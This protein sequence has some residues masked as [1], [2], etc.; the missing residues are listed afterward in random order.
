MAE[1]ISNNLK[2][3]IEDSPEFDPRAQ[4][5]FIHPL[6][7][8]LQ[9]LLESLKKDP[10]SNLIEAGS[11]MEA[12][13]IAQMYK[14]CILTGS[15][16]Q[17][18]DIVKMF[19][20]FAGLKS[21]I[22][23]NHIK[24]ML[25]SAVKDTRIVRKFS[26][27]GCTDY[28]FEPVPIRQLLHKFSLQI[29][30]NRAARKQR[31]NKDIDLKR[32]D[33]KQFQ[34]NNLN[35]EN[36]ANLREL[37]ANEVEQDCWITRGKPRL[38]DG[39]WNV[40]MIGPPTHEGRWERHNDQIWKYVPSDPKS[41]GPEKGNWYFSGQKPSYSRLE[42]LFKSD[43]PK[44]YFQD[45]KGKI[46][47]Y[48]LN[49]AADEKL[50]MA[51]D[52]AIAQQRLAEEK[53]QIEELANSAEPE[54][55][56]NKNKKETLS[57]D[58]HVSNSSD[59]EKETPEDETG[60][61]SDSESNNLQYKSLKT[62]SQDKA[63]ARKKRNLI[64]V[65]P[66]AEVDSPEANEDNPEEKALKRKRASTIV[67]PPGKDQPKA[68]ATT[69]QSPT[70]DPLTSKTQSPK[71]AEEEPTQRPMVPPGQI[72]KN[73]SSKKT[74][75]HNEKENSG[76][77]NVPK[78]NDP[79][80]NS[81]SGPN[82]T[83]AKFSKKDRAVRADG[84]SL[85]DQEPDP[86]KQRRGLDQRNF[87][88]KK[89]SEKGPNPGNTRPKV[90]DQPTLNRKNSEENG[91]ENQPLKSKNFL[92]K[93]SIEEKN[94]SHSED[95]TNASSR[96]NKGQGP[97]TDPNASKVRQPSANHLERKANGSG[98]DVAGASRKQNETI[99]KNL[100][101]NNGNPEN[102]PNP[103]KAAAKQAPK[104]KTREASEGSPTIGETEGSAGDNFQADDEDSPLTPEETS[105]VSTDLLSKDEQTL[106]TKEDFSVEF[107]PSA[108]EPLNASE[109]LP[110]LVLLMKITDLLTQRNLPL[111]QLTEKIFKI[112][113]QELKKIYRSPKLFL[114]QADSTLQ[115]AF[116][117][118]PALTPGRPVALSAIHKIFPLSVS[119]KSSGFL[120]LELNGPQMDPAEL[121]KYRVVAL[122]LLSLM[123][124]L[125]V[126]N[127]AKA[128]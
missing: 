112:L 113:F 81:S 62:E 89:D 64:E 48:K 92:K 14:P 73:S 46:L 17:D 33:Q 105:P 106:L 49:L 55:S 12:M 118:S 32:L 61:S 88:Q 83:P 94:Q 3:M 91:D 75:A 119:D 21:D 27:L 6:T 43:A 122:G 47:F 4:I 51:K 108:A 31:N 57:P 111:E 53:R 34:R 36:A 115:L 103:N 87:L 78:S 42:W 86:E 37:A 95:A 23:N 1:P 123:Q 84:D 102:T 97:S 124:C 56:P 82:Q 15:M 120:C 67:V 114:L 90:N 29:R 79:T 65:P 98:P 127:P 110:P 40:S 63:S 100:A 54:S 85:Q 58:E 24:T 107:D 60:E 41:L 77:S 70:N 69:S 35:Q 121:A 50:E 80:A 117:P 96:E 128:A 10:N 7:P 28:I 116:P 19:T 30:A 59:S 11:A 72:A 22:K 13:Q 74:A 38:I 104:R 109:T 8:S 18:S 66:G 39:T 2:D 44:L 16:T 101:D 93:K 125:T 99:K 68:P 71:S 52:S 26:D 20:L 76:P 9:K 5:I 25:L 126:K 45:A